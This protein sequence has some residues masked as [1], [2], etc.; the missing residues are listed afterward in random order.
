MSAD[1]TAAAAGKSFRVCRPWVV[2]LTNSEN[3][4]RVR[5]LSRYRPTATD[6]V[7]HARGFAS[8]ELAEAFYHA[9]SPYDPARRNFDAAFV[10]MLWAASA[11]ERRCLETGRNPESNLY[12]RVAASAGF[13]EG[14]DT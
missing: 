10:K 9:L 1:T 4:S 7:Y 14:G 2:L 8:R 13:P 12:V 11:H 5:L 3:P 6:A